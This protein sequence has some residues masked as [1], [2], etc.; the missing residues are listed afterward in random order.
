M[1]FG[2]IINAKLNINRIEEFPMANLIKM[3]FN[4]KM[5]IPNKLNFP[6]SLKD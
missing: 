3:A 2:Q 5:V 1:Y 6:S 4:F